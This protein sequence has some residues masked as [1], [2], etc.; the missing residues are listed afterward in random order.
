MNVESTLPCLTPTIPKFAH[1]HKPSYC[2]ES[3]LGLEQ[4]KAA[5]FDI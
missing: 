4:S 2:V 1:N 3:L 5:V